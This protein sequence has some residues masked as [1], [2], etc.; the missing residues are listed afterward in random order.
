MLKAQ[1]A[2]LGFLALAVAG[3]VL[4]WGECKHR[5]DIEET[6]DLSGTASLSI[7]AAAGDLEVVGRE[8][9]GEASV[10]ATICASRAEWLEESGLELTGGEVAGIAVNMPAVNSGMSWSGN[11]Y[12]SMDLVIEVPA[13]LALEISDSS[14]SMN[15][16]GT[17]GL[18][19]K[20][21]SGDIDIENVKGDVILEDS[22]GDVS[23]KKIAGDVTVNQD[24]S[25]DLYGR[26]I[27]GSVRIIK[28]SSGSIRFVDV[29]DDFIVERDSSGDIVA[30]TIGG[31]FKVLR[32]GSGSVR[33][34]DVAGN[35][36]VPKGGY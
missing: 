25:G 12:L 20:D 32:D 14:G 16:E 3:D 5:R 7:L 22:S 34:S 31:D 9:T 2:L 17:G 6:L 4:A 23:L 28:D 24:S 29:R 10:R 1:Q 30:D 33:H 35:V 36:D 27:E 13:D 26:G 15:L 8:G 11:Q 19:V 18:F 21:S